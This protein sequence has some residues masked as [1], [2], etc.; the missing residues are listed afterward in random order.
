MSTAIVKQSIF[1]LSKVMHDFVEQTEN[2]MRWQFA[3]QKIWP[4][5]VYPGYAEVNAMRKAAALKKGD[6]SGPWYSTGEGYK[7]IRGQLVSATTAGDVTIKFSYL[8]HLSFA[9]MGVGTGTKW[10]DVQTSKKANFRTRYIRKWERPK[11]QSH[12]PALLYQIR[13]LTY[14]IQGYL[15]DFYGYTEPMRMVR[16]LDLSGVINL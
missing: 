9:D 11:G 4:Y 2:Q 14:R 3:T 6:G 15:A 13:H 10:E 1:P 5:E 7:S 16:D 12:R 8:D